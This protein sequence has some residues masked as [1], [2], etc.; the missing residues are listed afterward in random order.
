MDICCSAPSSAHSQV[1]I[2]IRKENTRNFLTT[3]KFGASAPGA[4]EQQNWSSWTRFPF[5][6]ID[7]L[8]VKCIYLTMVHQLQRLLGDR[9]GV[10]DVWPTLHAGPTGL[11]ATW[12]SALEQRRIQR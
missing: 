8:S 5:I 1:I 12:Q 10:S 6:L 9:R 11:G 3:T 2:K 4:R 7:Q